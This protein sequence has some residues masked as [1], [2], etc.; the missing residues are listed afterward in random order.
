MLT[1]E[2]LKLT[3]IQVHGSKEELVNRN[4]S[5]LVVYSINIKICCQRCRDQ[6]PSPFIDQNIGYYRLSKLKD[7]HLISN[8]VV[9]C[10]LIL[11]GVKV[12]IF[13]L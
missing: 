7:V 8:S 9:S 5:T 6:G 2:D 10:V 12:G 4:L 13:R 3:Q 1:V 11:F